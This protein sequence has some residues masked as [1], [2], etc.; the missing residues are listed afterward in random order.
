MTPFS[1]GVLGKVVGVILGT[2]LPVH[3]SR[4][5]GQMALG[6]DIGYVSG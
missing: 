2:A 5:V 3:G 6:M 4:T 1:Y